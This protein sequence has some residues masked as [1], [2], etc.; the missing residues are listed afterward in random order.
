MEKA[1]KKN[2][3]KS[4]RKLFVRHG[5]AGTSMGKIA[6]L[7]KVNH[8]L[9]FYH[10]ESKAKLWLAVKQDIVEEANHRARTLPPST[11]PFRDFL[12]TIIKQGMDFYRK[13]PDIIR[14]LNWQR[15]ENSASSN[16]GVALSSESQAWINAFKAYQSQGILLSQLQPEFIVTM[17]LSIISSAALDP[18]IFIGNKPQQEAYVDFC[19]DRLEQAL[20]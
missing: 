12:K 18:N 14:M 20:T 3:L 17:L 19:V 1:T 9:L 6:L 7:A 15:L 10:F 16:I 4:A 5:F 13:N 11:L 2:I 8:S